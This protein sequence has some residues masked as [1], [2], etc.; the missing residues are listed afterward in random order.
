M[1]CR[2]PLTAG[3]RPSG[4]APR[5]TMMVM[6]RGTGVIMMSAARVSVVPAAAEAGA[7]VHAA[8]GRPSST[9]AASMTAASRQS[10]SGRQTKRETNRADQ[11]GDSR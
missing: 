4:T 11:R 8:K 1:P 5:T 2:V 10:R 6:T 9:V 7:K 3:V